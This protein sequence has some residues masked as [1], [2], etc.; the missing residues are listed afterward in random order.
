MAA[1]RRPQQPNK[2]NNRTR[3]MVTPAKETVKAY[4]K[5]FFTK[6]NKD[7]MENVDEDSSRDAI[8]IIATAITAEVDTIII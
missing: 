7:S 8:I 2:R 4:H 3:N 6:G 5:E 1:S